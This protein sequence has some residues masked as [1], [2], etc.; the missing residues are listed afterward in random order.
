MFLLAVHSP[1]FFTLADVNEHRLT[2]S[3]I[4]G[5]NHLPLHLVRSLPR[6]FHFPLVLPCTSRFFNTNKHEG[7]RA[8]VTEF[9]VN[10]GIHVDNIS[11]F[12][13]IDNPSRGFPWLLVAWVSKHTRAFPPSPSNWNVRRSS[14][15]TSPLNTL[16][17]FMVSHLHICGALPTLSHHMAYSSYDKY[18]KDKTF[19]KG[20]PVNLATKERYVLI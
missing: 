1:S 19:S 3:A 12:N 5:S 17:D 15:D 8:F 18:I 16:I 4:Q 10:F 9:F 13:S 20:R 2:G 14:M 6:R 7:P 11:T